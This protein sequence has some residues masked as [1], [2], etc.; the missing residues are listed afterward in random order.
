MRCGECNCKRCATVATRRDETRPTLGR[1]KN[2]IICVAASSVSIDSAL[3]TPSMRM[4]FCVSRGRSAMI[5]ETLPSDRKP[6]SS[7]SSSSR[8]RS[9][10][11]ISLAWPIVLARHTPHMDAVRCSQRT[12]HNVQHRKPCSTNA[13]AQPRTHRQPQCVRKSEQAPAINRQKE[14]GLVGWWVGG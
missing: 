9:S 2:R 11:P 3:S 6:A 5:E 1:S 14:G 7:T 8:F 13:T 4:R 10:S 12:A